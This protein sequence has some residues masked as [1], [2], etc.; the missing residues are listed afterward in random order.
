MENTDLNNKDGEKVH[1]SQTNKMNNT[2]KEQINKQTN[3]KT[4]EKERKKEKGHST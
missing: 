1:C 2:L 3:R 4:R